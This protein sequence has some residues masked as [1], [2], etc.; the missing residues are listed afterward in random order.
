MSMVEPNM[1]ERFKMVKLVK[2]IIIALCPLPELV[3]NHHSIMSIASASKKI[4]I[5]LC[6]LLQLMEENSSH[7]YA[8]CLSQ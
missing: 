3:K 2:K 5:A 4:I 1:K 7:Q 8:H 6:P